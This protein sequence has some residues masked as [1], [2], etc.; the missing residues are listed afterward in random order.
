MRPWSCS[1]RR[2]RYTS[3]T[4]TIEHLLL[5]LALWKVRTII[6]GDTK[7]SLKLWYRKSCIFDNS[8]A[9][10]P[11]PAEFTQETIRYY[12]IRSAARRFKS[13]TRLFLRYYRSFSNLRRVLKFC[14]TSELSSFFE[15]NPLL[16]RQLRFYNSPRFKSIFHVEVKL[17]DT[18]ENFKL[19]VSKNID[20]PDLYY[21]KCLLAAT[22][23]LSTFEVLTASPTYHLPHRHKVTEHLLLVR[24]LGA[25]GSREHR[26]PNANRKKDISNIYSIRS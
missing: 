19:Q 8:K 20:H 15:K 7:V 1:R 12:S 13:D 21:F 14:S 18:Q 4:R 3:I 24:P 11:Y 16:K 6:K 9:V 17:K 5:L 23:S 25:N 2:Y 22:K 26:V 10:D